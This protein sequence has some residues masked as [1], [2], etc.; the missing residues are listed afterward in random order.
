MIDARSRCD[1]QCAKALG[2]LFRSLLRVAVH[3]GWGWTFGVI[4]VCLGGG[5]L[6]WS[7]D[8]IREWSSR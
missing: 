2:S 6:W 8:L 4:G 7:W 3:Y 5:L 1:E